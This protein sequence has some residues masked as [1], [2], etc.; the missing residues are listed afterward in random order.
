L[1]KAKEE[2]LIKYNRPDGSVVYLEKH[3]SY[4]AIAASNRKIPPFSEVIADEICQALIEGRTI[5]SIARDNRYPD[6][7]TISKWRK[8]NPDFDAAIKD[9]FAARADY[10]H[11]KMLETAESVKDKDDAVVKRVAIDAYK[12]SAEKTNPDQYGQRTKIS[13]DPRAPLQLIVDTGVPAP[14]TF[15]EREVNPKLEVVKE[16]K[17][18]KSL[19]DGANISVDDP[20]TAS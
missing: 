9:A 20:E 8:H 18:N 4:D 7:Y 17:D 10:M 1:F 2:N 12:W 14:E 3:L 16:S 6:F 11:D 19:T 15:P 13:G 5:T